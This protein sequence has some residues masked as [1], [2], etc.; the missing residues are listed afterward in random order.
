MLYHHDLLE[1]ARLEVAN[2]LTSI[3]K[4]DEIVDLAA[5]S[6]LLKVD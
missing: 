6:G 3:V 4:S 1:T 5:A 2:L